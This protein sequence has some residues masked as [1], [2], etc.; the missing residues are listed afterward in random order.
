MKEICASCAICDF[1]PPQKQ[2][3]QLYFQDEGAPVLILDDASEDSTEA[4]RVARLLLGDNMTFTYTTTIRCTQKIHRVKPDR[5]DNAL[6]HCAVWTH[7]L[8]GDRLVILATQHGLKQMRIGHEMKEGSMSK[9][10]KWGLTLCIPPLS[11]MTA[12][13]IQHYAAQTHRLLVTAGLV[14]KVTAGP[15][16]EPKLLEK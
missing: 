10:I 4:L 6:Q 7:L 14:T 13:D 5:Y 11:S 8:T 15:K 12:Q 2:L 9:S 3:R 16:N 1:M